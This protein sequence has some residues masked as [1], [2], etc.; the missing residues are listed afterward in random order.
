M[1]SARQIVLG[2]VLMVVSIS[3]LLAQSQTT[4][5]IPAGTLTIEQD[6]KSTDPNSGLTTYNTSSGRPHDIGRSDITDYYLRFR[7]RLFFAFSQI[8]QGAR[9]NSCTLTVTIMNY[10]SG[11]STAKIV[12]MPASYGTD[13]EFWSQF[14]NTQT[15]YFT[16]LQY[17]QMSAKN[18]TS[19]TLTA[20]VQ[21][22][23]NGNGS[24]TLGIAGL[25]E[26]T[27][28]TS[29][30]VIISMTIN[31]TPKVTVTIQNSF[32]GGQIDVDGTNRNSGWSSTSPQWYS[33]ESHTIRA[34]TQ[35]SGGITYPFP[36]P[37][38]W[39]NVTTGE[40]KSQ[41]NNNT[42]VSIAPTSN[43]TW[44]ANYGTG[45][46]SVIVMN[47]FNGGLVKVEGA[48]VASGTSFP[49]AINSTHTLEA[50]NQD[51]QAPS[52]ANYFRVYQ[53]WSTPN[54]S[55]VSNPLAV[56][57]NQ[58][59]TYQANFAKQFNMSMSAASYIEG[60]SGGTY[61]LNG[62]NV[63]SS[64]SWTM[65]ESNSATLEAVPPSNYVFI[66]WND[67]S[68]QNPRTITPTDHTTLYALYKAHLA[69]NVAGVTNGDGQQRIASINEGAEDVL[70][71]C[72]ADEIWTTTHNYATNTWTPE[73]RLSDGLGGNTE[74]CIAA[75][76]DCDDE[77]IWGDG[78]YVTWQK[79]NANGTY[80]VYFAMRNLYDD[81]NPYANNLQGWNTAIKNVSGEYIPFKVS[82]SSCS[83]A[84]K[85]AV[86]IYR[87]DGGTYPYDFQEFVLI[88]YRQNVS[89]LR[90]Q[91]A[92]L[93]NASGWFDGFFY[94]TLAFDIATNH[95]YADNGRFTV[96]Q[97][98]LVH[99]GVDT[100]AIVYEKQEVDPWGY[101]LHTI[102]SFSY[103]S[104]GWCSMGTSEPIP[105]G[106]QSPLILNIEG[107][108]YYG[109]SNIYSPQV[110]R[111]SGKTIYAWT[112]EQNW[113]DGYHQIVVYQERNAT[114][115]WNPNYYVWETPAYSLSLGHDGTQSKLLWNVGN[116]IFQALK[117]SDNNW[118]LT[119]IGNGNN[120][121][122]MYIGSS[123]WG[124]RSFFDY[125]LF[126]QPG[127]TLQ[128]INVSDYQNGGLHK[129]A[130][131]APSLT[132]NESISGRLRDNSN[133]IKGIPVK[134][135]YSRLITITDTS[136][137]MWIS[138]GISQPKLGSRV[139]PF[140]AVSDSLPE[141]IAKNCLQYLACQPTT[142][143]KEDDTLSFNISIRSQNLK[144][145]LQPLFCD[146][147]GNKVKEKLA[148]LSFCAHDSKKGFA[149]RS[150]R[151]PMKKFKGKTVQVVLG[152]IDFK[153][154]GKNLEFSLSHVYKLGKPD[155]VKLQ[156]EA[157]PTAAAIP[158]T[159]GLSQNYPNPFN[160]STVLS[161][162]LPGVGT[163]YIV[164]LKVY[165]MIGREVAILADGMKE[166]GYYNATFDGSRF[167]SGVYFVRFTAQ[168]QD[169]NQPFTRTMKML[170][171]K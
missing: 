108:Y 37:G 81:A 152:G 29:A 47:S 155:T 58:A 101:S 87:L 92:Y 158:A 23:V 44:Q 97:P 157:E 64:Y 137:K 9:V 31:Y 123:F 120:P 2:M 78:I 167:S 161:Y 126:S 122:M 61:K 14:D 112:E 169:G 124:P 171:M 106:A 69:S 42:P 43:C 30:S 164:S 135:E 143:G 156:K 96:S 66:G 65:V 73:I 146:L 36:E 27:D 53:N 119:D 154:L 160:P 50:F 49:W 77:H 22:A 55:N 68:M 110:I 140:T 129:S 88:M 7:T 24:L 91:Y 12:K 17:S 11:S 76:G 56:T 116:T 136:K 127:P 26:G 10:N 105:A 159:F 147:N 166:A 131:V 48:N 113:D 134:Q 3:T 32:S 138:I 145:N 109:N 75:R 163:R 141:I 16:G 93:R 8:P 103:G 6:I 121:Q 128:S 74:P 168:P 94:P 63:G 57:I 142:V 79:Q 5:P 148:C 130:A 115:T 118:Q 165:D 98:E 89:T 13:S 33:G 107:D 1:K 132:K 28:N 133:N 114:G 59:Y 83:V 71:Y 54:G 25:N 117:I 70:V 60:G 62:T 95:M 151:V 144:T 20:D 82:A 139:I 170:M 111:R 85:P 46:A 162:Q 45:T 39:T 153:S 149:I 21:G 52:E 84:P 4:P 35:P 90:R 19:S 34:Y 51:Y 18:L 38:T 41:T 15:I 125:Y 150:I 99:T 102:N 80:D 67:G 40:T 100:I 104:T 86:S 72:S